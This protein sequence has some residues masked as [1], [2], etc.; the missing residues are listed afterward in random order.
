VAFE[1]SAPAM[2]RH[3][4]VL[5]TSGLIE[6]TGG[7]DDA[8]LRVYRLRRAPFVALQGW[9]GEVEA[10]WAAAAGPRGRGPLRADGRR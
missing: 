3:L 10:L 2:S 6:L 5:R 8:R 4:R 7:D 9:L 1:I